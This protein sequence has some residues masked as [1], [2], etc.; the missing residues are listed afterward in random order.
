M[1]RPSALSSLQIVSPEQETMFD[2]EQTGF[3]AP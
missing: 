1:A 2:E 3:D